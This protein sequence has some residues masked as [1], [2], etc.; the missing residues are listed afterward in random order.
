MGSGGRKAL[1]K[2]AVHV[3]PS[4]LRDFSTSSVWALWVWIVHPYWE[5]RP[6][7]RMEQYNEPAW[8]RAHSA[9]RMALVD[10]ALEC[11]GSGGSDSGRLRL[12]NAGCRRH[13]P[14]LSGSLPTQQG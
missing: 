11:S 7:L 13:K 6:F 1:D 12:W 3:G 14:V 10:Q 4:R 5:V 8:L 9:G 2:P